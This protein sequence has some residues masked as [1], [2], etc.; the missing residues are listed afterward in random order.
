LHKISNK[1]PARLRKL[2]NA[3]ERSRISS[4]WLA[5]AAAHSLYLCTGF[6]LGSEKTCDMSWLEL[7]TLSAKLDYIVP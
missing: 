1:L 2:A 4:W 5:V 6:R 7:R 3:A